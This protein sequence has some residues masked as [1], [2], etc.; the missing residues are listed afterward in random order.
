MSDVTLV[1]PSGLSY[2]KQVMYISPV[3][4]TVNWGNCAGYASFDINTGMLCGH[5]GNSVF[6]VDLE[7][8]K[9]LREIVEDDMGSRLKKLRWG[10]EKW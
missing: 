9:R 8:L 7:S 10:A 4:I 6:C 5:K 1:T 3:S 2:E